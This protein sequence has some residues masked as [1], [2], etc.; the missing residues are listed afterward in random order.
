VQFL[1]TKGTNALMAMNSSGGWLIEDAVLRFT[2]KS[3]H[4]ESDQLAASPHHGAINVA[5]NAGNLPQIAM[6]GTIRRV[7]IW[8]EGYLNAKNDTIQGIIVNAENPDIRI[9]NV[10]YYAPDY[11]SGT[12]AEGARGLNSTGLNT[13]V[14]NMLVV[15]RA[16][17]DNIFIQRGTGDGCVARVIVGCAA[18]G[19]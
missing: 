7:I 8:Q 3:L 18:A 14:K 15:G 1:K 13:T 4:P 17:R 10:A 9:E 16:V 5:T 11:K 2:A 19:R 6:G 12:S